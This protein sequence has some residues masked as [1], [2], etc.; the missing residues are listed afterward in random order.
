[1]ILD[2]VGLVSGAILTFF[3]LTYL[4]G[5]NPLYRLGLH[6][7]IGGLVGYSLGIALRQVIIPKVWE[8]LLRAEDPTAIGFLIVPVVL[9]I[10]LLIKGFPKHAYIGNL[11]TAYL[12]GVGTA[13]ALGGALLGTIIPQVNATGLAVSPNVFQ[14]YPLGI[15]DGLMII[16]GTI[17]T[18]MAFNFTAQ[19]RE[20]LAGVWSTLVKI[21]AWIGRL[22]LIAA[23]GAAFAGTLTASLTIF[24]GRIQYIIEVLANPELY[25]LLGF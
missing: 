17:C 4:F 11:S 12:L 20:G 3:I 2:L 14:S 6:L 13:V 19:R 7:F 1:M 5:D 25:R 9:S 21:A 8:P 16:I 10:L 18:L 22:F 15:A 23:F 24:I